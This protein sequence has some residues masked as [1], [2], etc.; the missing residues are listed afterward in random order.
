MKGIVR[1][2]SPRKGFGFIFSQELG[3]DIFVHVSDIVG[4]GGVKALFIDDEVKFETE[5]SPKGIKAIKVVVTM[6]GVR[7]DE[8]EARSQ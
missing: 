1:W 7:K 8:N 4:N 2:F 6:K 3:G 5:Q